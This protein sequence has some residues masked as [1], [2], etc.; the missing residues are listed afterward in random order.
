M[1]LTRGGQD[2]Q[3]TADHR[4]GVELNTA[5]PL[6]VHLPCHPCSA[7][8]WASATDRCRRDSL[9]ATPSWNNVPP[10]GPYNPSYVVLT[11]GC[12]FLCALSTMLG[13]TQPRAMS[14]SPHCLPGS[15]EKLRPSDSLN[16]DCRGSTKLKCSRL[17]TFPPL[18]LFNPASPCQTT[19]GKIGQALVSY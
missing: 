15:D 16:Q 13:K 12:S 7:R 17:S 4:A 10:E 18:P 5:P 14:V 6:A 11:T 1:A 3:Y 19:M 9:L 8:W 2:L